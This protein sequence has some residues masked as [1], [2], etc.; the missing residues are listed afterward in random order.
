MSS[1]LSSSNSIPTVTRMGGNTPLPS[2]PCPFAR[3]V[4]ESGAH[5]TLFGLIPTV[6]SPERGP[7]DEALPVT[8]LNQTAVLGCDWHDVQPAEISYIETN[9]QIPTKDNRHAR[10]HGPWE[11]QATSSNATLP[12]RS[13]RLNS[14]L[15]QGS[16]RDAR[17]LQP[18]S[19]PYSTPSHFCPAVPGF[20]AL[21]QPPKPYSG[22]FW[23]RK[24]RQG[25]GGGVGNKLPPVMP[26]RPQRQLAP[27]LGP[28]EVHQAETSKAFQPN[29]Q[30]S[31]NKLPGDLLI[32]NPSL[33]VVRQV[34][35]NAAPVPRSKVEGG[36]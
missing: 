34:Q 27:H 3:E 18:G 21:P 31:R 20:P 15:T 22:V 36:D 6:G 9:K 7:T 12:D 5:G 17:M 13:S 30:S 2:F 8:G 19:V 26:L 28:F 29:R 32:P 1:M 4:N 25:T 11:T 23:P 14:Q 35:E 10:Y 24:N 33:K 16:L